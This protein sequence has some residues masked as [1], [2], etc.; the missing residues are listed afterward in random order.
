MM[1]VSGLTV[2]FVAWLVREL[3]QRKGR[4]A[5]QP[6]GVADRDDNRGSR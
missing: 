6:P 2:V 1:V 3:W 4:C 5:E